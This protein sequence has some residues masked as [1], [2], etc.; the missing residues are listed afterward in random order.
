MKL[1]AKLWPKTGKWEFKLTKI[2][3]KLIL[4]KEKWDMLVF[5]LTKLEE[6]EWKLVGK[7]QRKSSKGRENKKVVGKN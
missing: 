7:K 6:S 2:N 1:G 5:N 3:G 4:V